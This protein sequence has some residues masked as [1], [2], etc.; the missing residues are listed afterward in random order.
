VG[1]SAQ[2]NKT[3]IRQLGEDLHARSRQVSR[4]LS[5]RVRA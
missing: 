1:F 2:L 5:G 3:A 4:A